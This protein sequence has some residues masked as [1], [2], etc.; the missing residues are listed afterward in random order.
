MSEKWG[1]HKCVWEMAGHL[2]SSIWKKHCQEILI[3]KFLFFFIHKIFMHIIL[4]MLFLFTNDY[5]SFLNTVYY[6]HFIFNMIFTFKKYCFSFTNIFMHIIFKTLFLS[7]KIC[8]SFVN[9][10]YFFAYYIK[11]LILIHK[12]LFLI[13]KHF[14]LRWNLLN[15]ITVN[16]FI[17]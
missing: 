12:K 13:H 6:M 10:A 17:W 15:G 3:H 14:M 5:F 7:T 9:T 4:K 16:E 2:L 1:W 8:F 11:Y